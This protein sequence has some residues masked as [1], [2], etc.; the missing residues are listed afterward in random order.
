MKLNA[1]KKV[2]SKEGKGGEIGKGRREKRGGDELLKVR[3][4]KCW[5]PYPSEFR[6]PA[7]HITGAPRA[8]GEVGDI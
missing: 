7:P 6:Q 1:E 5:D 3:G 4:V 8:C 2:R